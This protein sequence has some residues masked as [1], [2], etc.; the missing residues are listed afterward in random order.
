M[1]TTVQFPHRRSFIASPVSAVCVSHPLSSPLIQNKTND[2]L[3]SSSVLL[4]PA[5]LT[6]FIPNSSEVKCSFYNKPLEVTRGGVCVYVHVCVQ[7]SEA[8]PA[9]HTHACGSTHTQTALACVGNA[10]AERGCGAAQDA[11]D[12]LL[13]SSLTSPDLREC[14]ATG[15][16]AAAAF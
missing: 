1:T 5:Y 4:F 16:R 10:A 13:S 15:S 14:E 8:P 11:A 9:T 12:C 2:L 3:S 6:P 7:P